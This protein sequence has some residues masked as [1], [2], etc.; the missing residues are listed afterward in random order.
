MRKPLPGGKRNNLRANIANIVLANSLLRSM[1]EVDASRNVYV[2]LSWG[3]WY[4]AAIAGIDNRYRGIVEI[5]CGDVRTKKGA[6]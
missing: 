4:G 6:N 3:S 1:P 2:G 5:Y